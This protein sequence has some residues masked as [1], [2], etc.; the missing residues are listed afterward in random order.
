MQHR[1]MVSCSI[2]SEAGQREAQMDCG[3]VKGH[4]YGV[5]ALRKVKHVIIVCLLS[6]LSV[7]KCD[8]RL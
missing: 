5:T 6:L 4:A 3:L 7:H 2:K 8:C 1:A